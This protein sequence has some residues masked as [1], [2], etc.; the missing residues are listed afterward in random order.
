MKLI[1]SLATIL[2]IGGALWPV[3]PTVAQ[4]ITR[5]P[6]Q[7]TYVQSYRPDAN[8]GGDPSFLLGDGSFMGAGAG[9][10][11]TR[12]LFQFDL[13][14]LPSGIVSATLRTFEYSTGPAAGPMDAY[15]FPVTS[16]W[17][18]NSVTWATR[19]AFSL[20]APVVWGLFSPW[21]TAGVGA[22]GV[23]GGP[24][25]RWIDWDVTALVR[26][27]AAGELVNQGWVIV[28]ETELLSAGASRLGYFVSSDSLK[29]PTH[30]PQLVIVAVPEPSSLVLL[31]GG[32]ISLFGWRH[33]RK[34]ADRYL[35]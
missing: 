7:D 23:G 33:A 18:Q 13:T 22:A 25:N 3:V 15:L 1:S 9:V 31:L 24:E 34:Q 29:D 11:Y 12:G 28:S 17:N 8:Y 32:G 35:G 19:P 14:G 20:G 5:T 6:V 30:S 2:A 26:K 16:A 10:G 27:Q 21:A 4:T